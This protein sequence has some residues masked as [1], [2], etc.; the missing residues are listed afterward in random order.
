MASDSTKP[1][2]EMHE[3]RTDKSID[4]LLHQA[5]YTPAELA[6][7]LEVP[8][9]LIEHEAFAGNLKAHIIEHRVVSIT[10]EDAIAWMNARS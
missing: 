10:R 6:T 5:D 9:S 7:L 1:D 4:E 2:F 8:L 3:R